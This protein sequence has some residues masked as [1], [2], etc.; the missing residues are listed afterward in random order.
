ME[1]EAGQIRSF[2]AIE[3]PSDVKSELNS[4]EGK[5]REEL[6]LAVRW[7]EPGN[8][9]LTLKFLGNMPQEKVSRIADAVAGVAGGMSPFSLEFGGLGAFPNM[10]RPRV[11]WVGLEG[12]IEKLISLQQGV[13]AALESLGFARET[14]PFASHLTLARVRERGV[15]GGQNDWGKLF[16]SVKP[17]SKCC[18]EV[19][20]ISLMRSQLTPRGAI[21]SRLA[22]AELQG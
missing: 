20:S 19:K 16:A 9:H 8:I 5:L 7:V 4:L 21:Y 15:V 18:F 12:E 1:T 14:R 13:D 22:L 10:K 3:L 6:H 11:I 2:I 17:E